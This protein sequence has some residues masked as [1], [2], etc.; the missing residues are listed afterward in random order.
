MAY[1]VVDC[2]GIVG[3]IEDTG[4]DKS[5]FIWT[6]KKFDIGYSDNQVCMC[7]MYACVCVVCVCIVC[8]VCVCMHMFAQVCIYVCT[9]TCVCLCSVY[10]DVCVV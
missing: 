7:A 8:V 5:Y 6:H 1:F 10:I 2:V 4:E 9:H 3:E